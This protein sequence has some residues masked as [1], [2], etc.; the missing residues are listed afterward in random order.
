M[1]LT[2]EPIAVPLKLDETGTVRVSGTRVTLDTIISAYSAGESPE[3]I[4]EGFP[5]VPLADIHATIAWYLEHR[6]QVDGYLQKCAEDGAAWRS[7]WESRYD[8]QA[9]RK[10]LLARRAEMETEKRAAADRG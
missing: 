2:F 4:A 9:I 6:E 7:F 1:P 3:R 5:S 10:R 8:K